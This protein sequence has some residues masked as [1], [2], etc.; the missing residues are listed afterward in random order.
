MT[1]KEITYINTLFLNK[2]LLSS[3]I[4]KD[5]ENN[6]HKISNIN[7]L[8][9]FNES[10][11]KMI[12]S[13]I[14]PLSSLKN[15]EALY[16]Y[17]NNQ[18]L[19]LGIKKESFVKK[20]NKDYDKYE[21][22]EKIIIAEDRLNSICPQ[23]KENIE[24]IVF[25]NP[26]IYYKEFIR[27][28]TSLSDFGAPLKGVSMKHLE[29]SICMDYDAYIALLS[30]EISQYKN[31]IYFLESLSKFAHDI[32][33]VFYNRKIRKNI[34]SLLKENIEQKET[35]D[36]I[37]KNS[38]NL[39]S[40][41]SSIKDENYFLTFDIHEYNVARAGLFYK[42]VLNDDFEL[43]NHDEIFDNDYYVN[44]FKD[45]VK[46]DPY[47]P[48]IG[49]DVEKNE[50]LSKLIFKD[51]DIH[52]YLRE[53]KTKY[54]TLQLVKTL[55][56]IILDNLNVKLPTKIKKLVKQS[57]YK[58]DMVSSMD[59]DFEVINSLS[60]SREKFN[61]LLENGFFESD[62][63]IYT[64]KLI[65]NDYPFLLRDLQVVDRLESAINIRENK[66]EKKYIKEIKSYTKKSN[67]Y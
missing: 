8:E 24:K 37:R 58:E 62:N 12:T 55:P 36:L 65:L 50:F 29:Q 31:N 44:L 59:Y 54:S 64:I 46:K 34:L 15:V 1:T 26:D 47:N 40:K 3:D 9:Y 27:R 41:I 66:S 6:K 7:F 67:C 42:K 53:A 33:E 57:S 22:Y 20:H 23:I 49:I 11:K 39:F 2:I 25:K 48:V 17:Y 4:E 35:S 52:L 56:V 5:I 16:E 19:E 28:Y 43:D 10:V 38:K 13:N 63:F 45:Y 14:Y 18:I 32:Q 60:C 30:G 51:M 21:Y 61:D